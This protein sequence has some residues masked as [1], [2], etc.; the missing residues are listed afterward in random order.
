M[1]QQFIDRKEELSAL[2]THYKRKSHQLFIIY[3]RRRVG[4][5]ELIKHFIKS[6]PHI[7]FLADTRKDIFNI[8]ELQ[9]LMSSLLDAP[10]FEKAKFGDWYELFEGFT[11]ELGKKQIVM[12][13][14]EFPY[15]IRA[16][17]S[18][19]SI[20]QKVIDE[21]LSKTNIFLILCGSSIS[22][23]ENE[24]LAYK[25]PLY[26]RRTG[27]WKLD[28]LAFKFVREFFPRY[29]MAD[30]IRLYAVTDAIPLYLLKFE[31]GKSLSYNI[32]NHLFKKGEFM[33]EEAEFL[34]KEE[35]REPGNY[36]MILKA[37]A[38]GNTK[39]ADILNHTGM[40]K[41]LVSKYIDTLIRLRIIAKQFPVTLSKEKS[42]DTAYTFVDNYY[43]FWFRFVYTY[44][45]MLEEGK[46]KFILSHSAQEFNQ[47]VSFVFENVARQFLSHPKVLPFQFSKIGKWW[48]KEEE[49]D[50]VALNNE[51]K[52]IAFA[53]CKWKEDV[54]AEKLLESLVRKARNVRWNNQKRKE[55]YCIFAKSFKR[56]IK[57]ENVFLFDLDDFKRKM[58]K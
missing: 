35:L 26:G 53:E 41:T 21:I 24:V 9:S 45:N 11:N 20:F 31:P 13:I 40:D 34:L 18:I 56:R 49:I 28:P 43:L 12:V 55:Y 48:Q 47:H 58:I 16:N 57:R 15:L 39:F 23:M 27:Q 38:H 46:G 4:K 8:K 3:G 14:D 51:T 1:N 10:L 50:I 19:T 33:Y 42:R 7:Y 5:T 17:K 37:I 30:L 25:S 52:E 54:D 29:S 2:E 32:A 22:M 36:F 44:R 6:K